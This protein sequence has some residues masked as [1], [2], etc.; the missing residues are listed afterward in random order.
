[1]TAPTDP[2]REAAALVAARNADPSAD[3][4]AEAM[5]RGFAVA[6]ARRA[7]VPAVRR[8]AYGR[9]LRL[10]KA[11]GHDRY[12][13]EH[14]DGRMSAYRE[15]AEI[16][17]ALRANLVRVDGENFGSRF[18]WLCGSHHGSGAENFARLRA[19]ARGETYVT[20]SERPIPAGPLR[21]EVIAELN[22]AAMLDAEVL[23]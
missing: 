4:A 1:M 11:R 20:P 15:L 5:D 19:Q 6:D 18:V 13:L 7:S 8:L 23:P 12:A 21:P 2:D 14:P 10:T 22:A 16:E 3:I 9:G 17:R